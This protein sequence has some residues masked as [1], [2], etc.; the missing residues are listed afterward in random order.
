MVAAVSPDQKSTTGP[1]PIVFKYLKQ[2]NPRLN[3]FRTRI[4]QALYK[5]GHHLLNDQKVM[6]VVFPAYSH[7]KTQSYTERKKRAFYENLFASVIDQVS[8]GLAQDPVR[9][10]PKPGVVVDDYWKGLMACAVPPGVAGEDQ[11]TFDQVL[12]DAVVEALVCCRSF[13]QADLPKPSGD[14]M[15][16][17]DQEKMGE[18]SA[19]LITWSSDKIHDWEKS[20]DDDGLLWLKTYECKTFASTPDQ[21]RD[22]VTHCWTIWDRDGWTRYECEETIGDRPGE[23]KRLPQDEELVPPKD[24]GTHSFGVV[25]WIMIDLEGSAGRSHLHIGDRLESLCRAHF[26]RI[27]GE[28]FQWTQYNFQQMYEFLAPEIGGVDT[29]V[30]EN[31]TDPN[32]ANREARAPGA[33]HVRGDKD[34]AEF[35]GPD[36]GGAATGQQAISDLRDAIYRVTAQMALSQDTSGAMLKRSA[37]SKKQDSVAQEIVLGAIGKRVLAVA[38]QCVKM[39]ARGRAEDMPP[40]IDGY[41]AFN[42]EDADDMINQ[43]VLLSQ[44]EIPSATYKVESL[45]RLAITHLGDGTSEDVRNKIR[46]ELEQTITQDQMMLRDPAGGGTGDQGQ[47]DEGDNQP[48]VQVGVKPD[49]T[50]SLADDE[51]P[52]STEQSIPD[53]IIETMH[54]DYPPEAIEWVRDAQ[55][56][57]PT[58]VSLD[59]IDYSNSSNW[60][61]AEEPDKISGQSQQI[62]DGWEKP[63]V[64]VK[65]PSMDKLMIID[66]HHRAL[67][68]KH[69]EKS[70][71]AYVGVV[72]EDEGPWD[73]THD[74]QSGSVGMSGARPKPKDMKQINDDAEDDDEED[75]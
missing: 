6:D 3:L 45:Y 13:I 63:M 47:D 67:A 32:R 8:A 19:Y 28:Q 11:R 21:P 37:D 68:Y 16:L 64:L 35:V 43:S 49:G 15:S 71:L 69:L 74:A 75:S 50:V 20:Q 30:G 51:Q 48:G 33:V 60:Y 26:N 1:R 66:G 72:P 36:M 23:H 12:R 46:A 25:P 59:Q 4:L 29:P 5:G 73:D 65:K 57:G 58:R 70:A 34:R 22:V 10:K 27:N 2:V 61:A 41:E 62:A 53:E 38:R 14:A 52:E 31:Q 42:V 44:V 17:M 18:L 40:E 39:L 24:N 7:E 55:W 9:L 56:E 54:G